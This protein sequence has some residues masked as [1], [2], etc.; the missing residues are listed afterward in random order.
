MER[1]FKLLAICCWLLAVSSSF[2]SCQE[3]HEAG[4]LFGQWRLTESKYISFSGSIVAFRHITNFRPREVFGNFQHQGD[5]LFIQCSSIKK[6]KLD[7]LMV[8]DEL[9]MKPFTNIRVKIDAVDSDRLILSK[10][11]KLWSFKKW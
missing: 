1:Y 5:S 3:G 10:D 4:D 9:G 2:I 8:E 6:D 11:G 7:T